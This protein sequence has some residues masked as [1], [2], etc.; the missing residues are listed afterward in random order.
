MAPPLGYPKTKKL[1][2]SGGPDPPTSLDPA[3][4]SAPDPRAFPQLQ[5][6]HYTTGI[7]IMTFIILLFIT[8]GAIYH[9]IWGRGLG[10]DEA[11]RSRHRRR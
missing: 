2:A 7:N 10:V 9:I 5:I 1:S 11:P 8:G 6:C 3:G 4:G